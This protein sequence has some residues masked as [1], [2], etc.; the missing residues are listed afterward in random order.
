[1]FYPCLVALDDQPIMFQIT[2]WQS[3]IGAKGQLHFASRTVQHALLLYHICP[4]AQNLAL[5]VT[6]FD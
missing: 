1:M 2:V 6:Q 4:L 5:G 3:S